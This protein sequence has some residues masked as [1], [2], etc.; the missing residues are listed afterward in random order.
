[1]IYSQFRVS[2]MR[3]LR[4]DQRMFPSGDSSCRLMA[5]ERD[6]FSIALEA[7]NLLLLRVKWGRA[8]SPEKLHFISIFAK[9][10]DIYLEWNILF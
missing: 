8:K 2:D 10:L 4:D 7:S 9:Y 3:E 1:M 6:S 5:S